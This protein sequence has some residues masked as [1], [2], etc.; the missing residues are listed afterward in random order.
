MTGNRKRLGEEVGDVA[1]ALD[2]DDAKMSLADPVPD[3]MQAHVGG[4]GHPLRHRVGSDADGHLVV[5]E[6][7]GGGLGVAHVGQDFA[8]LCRER[9]G[10][11]RISQ[12]A[13]SASAT[14]EQ[15]TGMRVEWQE[16]GWLTQSSSSVSPR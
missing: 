11:R 4:L 2:E 14:K 5:A 9:C 1:D 15:T 8:F 6:Q 12:P 13:Y 10:Q 7:R 16:M 3:P